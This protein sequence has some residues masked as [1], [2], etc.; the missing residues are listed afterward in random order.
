MV[1]VVSQH[2]LRQTPV[3]PPVD[4]ITDTSKNITSLRPVIIPQ[5]EFPTTDKKSVIHGVRMQDRQNRCLKPY[6]YPVK[7]KFFPKFSGFFPDSKNFS[8]FSRFSS[9]SEK[10]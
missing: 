3:L 6:S 1:V 7:A 4:R 10:F 8:N 2:A 9:V 5:L